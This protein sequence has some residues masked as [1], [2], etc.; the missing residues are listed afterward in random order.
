MVAKLA[1]DHVVQ[2]SYNP[3]CR[4]YEGLRVLY[5]GHSIGWSTISCSPGVDSRIPRYDSGLILEP[6]F[7]LPSDTIFVVRKWAPTIADCWA[8][9]DIHRRHKDRI[10]QCYTM[11]TGTGRCWGARIH[12]SGSMSKPVVSF[13]PSSRS[14]RA[15]ELMDGVFVK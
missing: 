12:L 13:P 8:H 5:L 6:V 15:P 2:V 3:G 7:R 9:S 11:G 1:L 14:L 10:L 4:R